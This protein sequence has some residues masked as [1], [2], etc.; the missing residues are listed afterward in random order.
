[1]IVI[2]ESEKKEQQHYEIISAII[3]CTQKGVS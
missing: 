1:M 2:V 3:R